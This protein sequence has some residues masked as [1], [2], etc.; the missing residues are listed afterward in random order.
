MQADRIYVGVDVSKGYADFALVDTRGNNLVDPFQLDDTKSS[1]DFLVERFKT[2]RKDYSCQ[3]LFVVVESTGGYEDNWLRLSRRA[4][5]VSWVRGFRINPKVIHHSYRV[6]KR[7]SITDRVSAQTIALYAVKHP[8]HFAEPMA[9]QEDETYKATRSLIK[10]LVSLEKACTAQI[11]ALDKLL[12]VYL[13]SLVPHR[14]ETWSNYFLEIIARYTSRAAIQR[15]AAQGFKAVKRTPKTKAQA[16][17]DSL[18]AGH[19][20]IDTPE[21]IVVTMRSK[22]RQIQQLKAEIKQLEALLLEQNPCLDS[23]VD[24]LC[25]IKGFGKR[26]A[27]IL[28]SF[29][30]DFNRFDQAA[31]M[32]AF[33]GVVPR[34]KQSGDGSIK[35]RMSKQGN[36]MVRRE[37]YLI[38]FRCLKHQPYLRAIYDKHR[39]KGHSHDAALGILMHKI[40]RMLY[41]MLKHNKAYSVETDVINQTASK[42]KQQ[43]KNAPK[44]AQEVEPAKLDAP[45]SRREKTQTKTELPVPSSSSY[46]CGIK[47]SPVGA[48]L[49]E[50]NSA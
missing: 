43:P 6:Q 30:E 24:L 23:Q 49:T 8:E 38:A 15:A 47:G 13:P 10:H 35:P 36:A 12:Y 42:A 22:A 48:N 29:I 4:E 27:V 9:F 41:G 31:K 16:I 20:P 2:W 34:L 32:A 26:S 37:L 7:N 44:N 3:D 50:N 45:I 46:K 21:F 28:L 1:H 11:N 19:D 18:K 14:P 25:S 17:Y 39:L 40:V 33:F 5:L